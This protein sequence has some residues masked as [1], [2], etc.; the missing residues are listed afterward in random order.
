MTHAV[1]LMHMRYMIN[2]ASPRP[3]FAHGNY[4]K[5][6]CQRPELLPFVS[7]FTTVGHSPPPK[8]LPNASV[9]FR[10]LGIRVEAVRAEQFS[11]EIVGPSMEEPM[12]S[13][14]NIVIAQQGLLLVFEFSSSSEVPS[15]QPCR[16]A[17]AAFTSCPAG[18]QVA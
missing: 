6:G 18:A 7:A 17:Y 15:F 4:F 16:C 9:G 8:M 5:R 10:K 3:K 1:T 14:M 2:P 11:P 12:F 13:V